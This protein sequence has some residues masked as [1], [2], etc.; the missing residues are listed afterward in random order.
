MTDYPDAELVQNMKYNIK[1]NT[2][3]A[4]QERVSVQVGLAFSATYVHL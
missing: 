4:D 3:A 2:T 1:N